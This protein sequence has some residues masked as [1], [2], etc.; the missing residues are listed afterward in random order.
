MQ[1]RRGGRESPQERSPASAEAGQ[2]SARQACLPDVADEAIRL[3]DTYFALQDLVLMIMGAESGQLQQV[4]N[5]GG[6]DSGSHV[7]AVVLA[8]VDTGSFRRF[9]L[10]PPCWQ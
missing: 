1:Q 9:T 2:G 5:V 3:C 10:K 8:V 7:A 4:R 6:D